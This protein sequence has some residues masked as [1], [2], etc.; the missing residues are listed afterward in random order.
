MPASDSHGATVHGEAS[1]PIIFRCEDTGESVD[2]PSSSLLARP[3]ALRA[4]IVRTDVQSAWAGPAASAVLVDVSAR[5]YRFA[6]Y[7]PL[8][9]FVD[10][11]VVILLGAFFLAACAQVFFYFPCLSGFTLVTPAGAPTVG[12]LNP[13]YCVDNA[14]LATLAASPT[15][16]AL[17]LVA[18]KRIAVTM[19]TFGV[20]MLGAIAGRFGGAAAAA[21]YVAMVCV[22][23]PFQASSGG[24]GLAMWNKGAIVGVSGGFFWGFIA[25]A[26]IMGRAMERGAGRGTSWRSALWLVPHMV[27]AELAIY[28]CGLFWY[29]FSKAILAGVAVGNTPVL[30]CS[31]NLGGEV[32]ASKCLYTIFNIMMV[33]Y[34]PGECFKMALV[35]ALVPLTWW[36]LLKW[37]RW[38]RGDPVTTIDEEEERAAEASDAAPKLEAR[39]VDAD[40]RAA[41][42]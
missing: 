7:P 9:F 29:P 18:S 6:R 25:A 13:G 36:A 22:G 27:C 11:R 20:M 17:K 3:D 5:T 30:G 16:A 23:A 28:A 38:R 14:V 21:L 1:S 32:S 40:A 2:V 4:R 10:T 12:A 39:N 31:S 24:V 15:D 33:P 34:L 35:L 41:R 19:Q 42:V 37:Q 26:L 8:S